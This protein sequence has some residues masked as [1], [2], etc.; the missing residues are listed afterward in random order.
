MHRLSIA[1]KW[2]LY[3]LTPVVLLVAA[4]VLVS[5]FGIRSYFY[6]ETENYL[7]EKANILYKSII[8]TENI[9]SVKILVQNYEE[10]DKIELMGIDSQGDVVVTSSGF[11]IDV[12]DM[13]DFQKA[14]YSKASRGVYVGM[15]QTGHKI[16]AVSVLLPHGN[17]SLRAIRLVVSIQKVDARIG[18]LTAYV[19]IVG[20]VII[21]LFIWLGIYFTRSIIHPLRNIS[22]VANSIAEGHF[23]YRLMTDSNDEI[24]DLCRVINHMAEELG[25]T[26]DMQNE[27]ISSVSHELRTPLTAIQGWVETLGS[28]K[29]TSSPEYKEGMKIVTSETERLSMMVEELLDFSR[30]RL[31]KLAMN[32]E[33]IDLVAEVTEAYL[34]FKKRAEIENKTLQYD[35]PEDIIIAVGDRFRLKQVFINIID[36]ALKYS[37]EGSTV[38]VKVSTD[39]EFV[40]IKV[41]DNGNGIDAKDLPYIKNKFYKADNTVK[42]SGIGLAVADEIITLHSGE[43]DI[44][45]EKGIGT[46]VTI[47]LP[48]KNSEE[49]SQ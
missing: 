14:A 48:L 17:S 37:G 6:S 27:F 41:I 19:G 12:A 5:F 33:K 28:I 42:G 10:K 45:S 46:V 40:T 18:E 26:E 38:A 31:G 24:G 39:E 7:N 23:D 30:I 47:K 15:G 4:A 43:L 13:P 8:S 44:A 36:N 16:M 2:I 9:E 34:M 11:I 32:F 49:V 20:L 1:K 35:E 3:L 22:G 29:D 21:A 25:K